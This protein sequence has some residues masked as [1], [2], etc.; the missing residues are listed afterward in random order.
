MPRRLRGNVLPCY[1]LVSSG[2][3]NTIKSKKK[4]IAVPENES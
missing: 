3:Y 2:L 4:N 1:N